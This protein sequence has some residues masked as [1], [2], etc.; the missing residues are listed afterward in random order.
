MIWVAVSLLCV[1]SGL[2]E[3]LRTAGTLLVDVSADALTASDGDAIAQWPNSGTLGG[4]FAAVTNNAGVSFT[5]SLLGKKAVLFAAAE[6]N[7]L[8]NTVATPASLT[9]SSAWSMEAW[10]WVAS[11]PAAKSVYLAW[12]EDNSVNSWEGSRVMFRYDNGGTAIDNLNG[13]V[14]FSYGIPPAGAWHHIVVV[15]NTIK[16][17]KVFVDGNA[18]SFSWCSDP[19]QAGIP[20]TLGAV[21]KYN[22]P[23]V[24][25]NFFS[26]AL[27]RVRVHTGMLSDQ[28]VLHNYLA[29]ALSYS[30]ATSTVW[31]GGSGNWNDSANWSNGV[32]GASSKAVRILSGT[33]SVTNNV[34]PSILSSLDI[35]GAT[36]S[37]ADSNARIE[38]KTPLVVGRLSGSSAA[39]SV[40]RG[41]VVAN[42]ALGPMVLSLG[43]D[44]AS[45]S[46]VVGSPSGSGYV[47]SSQV[48]AFSGAADV[49]IISN[50]VLELDAFVAETPTNVPSITVNGGTLRSRTGY[51]G[52]GQFYNVPQV[53]VSTGGA[54]FD[55]VSSSTQAV[56]TAPIHDGAGAA[57]D[58]GLR[59]TSAGMLILS[60]TNSYNGDTSV[61]AGTLSL[62]TRLTDG[63]VY[64]LDAST[65]ALSTMQ[66]APDNSN[67]VSW[68]DA[69]GSGLLFATNKA[70]RCPV[71]DATL[72]NGR[73]GLRFNRDEDISRRL[74]ANRISR[75]Q[76]VFVVMNPASNNSLGGLWGL[77]DG[78]FGIRLTATAVQFCGNGNDFAS[79]GWCYVNGAAGSGFT[80]GQPLVLTSIGG[81]AQ[82]WSVAIGSYSQYR[83]HFRGD[84]AEILVYDRKL[85]D[86]ERQT[87]E[88]YLMAKWLGT[89]S[90]PQFGTSV[91]PTN[92]VLNVR[93]GAAVDLGGTSVQLAALNGA[94]SV[95]NR[96]PVSSALTVGSLDADSVFAGAITGKVSV[97]KV[98][99]GVITLAGPNSFTEPLLVQ[100]GT[101]RIASNISGITGLVYR[102]D[103]SLTNSFSLLADGTNVSAWTDAAGSGFSFAA[104]DN[105]QCP[106]YDRTLF[107]GRGGFRFGLGSRRRMVGSAVTNAQTVFAVNM[108][109]D[110][111]NDNGGFWGRNLED[112]GL[113]LGGTSWYYPGNGDDFHNA[114]GGGIVY[115][116]GVISNST[117]TIGQPHLVTSVCGS[118]QSFTPA[119]G[120]Y[121]NSSTWSQRFYRGEVAEILVYDRRLSDLER[122]I[123]EASLMAKWF[124]A[125]SGSVLPPTAAVTVNAGAKLDLLANSMTVAS[126]AG[127]GLVTNGTLTVTGDVAPDGTLTVAGSPV[128]TGTL[129]LDIAA[130]GSGDRLSV[131]GAL[132]LSGLAFVP[133]LPSAKPTAR[134]QT[135]VTASGGLTGTFETATLSGSWQ[136]R[137][138]ATS[139]RLVYISGTMIVLR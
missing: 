88:K 91:L 122:Q 77:A 114:A 60:G 24:F 54:V 57:K 97:T 49:Q 71:Y 82:T 134:N 85:D 59:K 74:T 67:V 7:A 5:N 21:K 51:Y 47:L 12:T 106:V 68:A 136:L 101:L 35:V 137:Y 65:N 33:V 109:R 46:L 48:R 45:S 56:S 6:R 32:V 13:S 100:S 102:L 34:S 133:N 2:T 16:Q 28:D 117:A 127:G 107:S 64:R 14:G 25:T 94:G 130:D 36:V 30:A 86:L 43:V 89:V 98:G 53:K 15:R 31:T 108:L 38:A 55:S 132:N 26:G 80:V 123:V 37:L 126:L 118:R 121:W 11:I 40:S 1:L 93:A 9:G 70:E 124:P 58:G 22:A 111:S 79:S 131:A 17:E 73:G 113:R 110:G 50:G 138:S 125:T 90:A 3:E 61:E 120:D 83:R 42:G 66:F 62:A 135:V 23:A 139:V 81:S 129:K 104:T 69:N 103:A 18:V 115:M 29:D 87:V 92:T 19:A 75:A 76:S 52:F 20:L 10:A 78:D 44:G 99:N 63:L 96:N 41:S 39:L 116:N 4:A 27:S 112:K 95:A 119:I 128:L 84:L 105:S 72:F 8:T